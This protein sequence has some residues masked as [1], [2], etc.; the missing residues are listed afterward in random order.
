MNRGRNR[1]RRTTHVPLTAVGSGAKLT[2]LFPLPMWMF[3]PLKMM[4]WWVKRWYITALA[5]SFYFLDWF[6][7]VFILLSVPMFLIGTVAVHNRHH[8]PSAWARAA[9]R[10][11]RVRLSWTRA[12]EAGELNDGPH[13]PR[14]TTPKRPL[15]IVNDQGTALEFTLNLARVGLTVNDL[16]R[17]KDYVAA[18]LNARR[19]RVHRLTP[20]IARFTIEWERKLSRSSVAN[21]KDQIHASQL[22]R[23][24]LDQDVL[25]ELDTSILVVG[26]SGSGKSNLTWDIFNEM[27]DLGINYR[28]YVIDPKKV[29]LADLLHSPYT[30]SYSDSPSTADQTIE[31]FYNSM[32]ATFETMKK[33]GLRKIVLDHETPLNILVIDELLL[34]KQAKMGIDTHLG[35]ILS[36]GRAAG[37]IVIAN[38]QLG[39]IDAISRLR[40]LFPQR[41]CMAVKSGDLTNAV[42]GPNA[43]ARGARCTEITEKGVGYVFTDFTGTF[44]RFKPPYIEDVAM[45]SRGEV[46]RSPTAET[47]KEKVE[48]LRN[49]HRACYT[50]RLYDKFGILLYVGIA[51][52][53]NKRIPDHRDKPFWEAINH[54]KTVIRKYPN[55]SAAREAEQEAIENE[56]P[57]Y[58]LIHNHP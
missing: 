41:V 38:S 34:C 27:N 36:A 22:P 6:W 29:E 8:R 7:F 40:D 47:V 24:E 18:T 45:V 56:H 53:P 31:S 32:M 26:E 1:P 11:A 50:Y 25:I 49:A 57:R 30:V 51:F 5:L 28:L 33:A 43:Q 52:N 23:I 54:G 20:G 35:E 46:Y 55:E 17:G 10:L 12:C 15:K 13:R 19:T 58:N 42:L 39:Q 44:Q 48:R 2:D 16:E 37:H 14:L 9:L 21:P 4:A 3:I